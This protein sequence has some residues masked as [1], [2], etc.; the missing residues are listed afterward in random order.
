MN[1]IYRKC[2]Y[3][4]Q[5]DLPEDIA[6]EEDLSDINWESYLQSSMEE[7]DAWTYD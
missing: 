5:L 7:S 3:S 1:S 4:G 2:P 6:P